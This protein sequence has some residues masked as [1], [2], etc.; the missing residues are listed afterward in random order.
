MPDV[1]ETSYG[2]ATIFSGDVK[3]QTVSSVIILTSIFVVTDHYTEKKSEAGMSRVVGSFLQ[4]CSNV[5]YQTIITKHN[6]FSSYVNE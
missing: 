5:L 1:P 4:T 6:Y 2:Y 3:K